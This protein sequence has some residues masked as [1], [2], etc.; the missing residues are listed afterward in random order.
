MAELTLT[1]LTPEREIF[2]GRV[3]S[4][5]APATKGSMGVLP[6]HAAL[7]T[8]LET[9]VVKAVGVDG[10]VKNCRVIKPLPHLSEL[11]LAAMQSMTCKP[12]TF[13]GQAISIDYVQNF[14]FKLPR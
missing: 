11:A 13:Q 3:A 1:I 2:S 4:L 8:S 5:T 7:M 9:G 10:S 14:Q 12:A 6:G